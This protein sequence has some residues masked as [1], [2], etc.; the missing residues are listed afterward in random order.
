VLIPTLLSRNQP[1]HPP[2]LKSLARSP[3]NFCEYLTREKLRE[4]I[5]LLARERDHNLPAYIEMTFV[6]LRRVDQRGG[7]EV[8][9][10]MFYEFSDLSFMKFLLANGGIKKEHLIRPDFGVE[11]TL[12]LVCRGSRFYDWR[13]KQPNWRQYENL[14]T[15]PGDRAQLFPPTDRKCRR[16]CIKAR[17]A[18][19]HRH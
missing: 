14:D 5:F 15:D 11:A 8:S 7:V 9:V 2:R 19:F 17:G 16:T 10:M 6:S 4:A 13:E 1:E 3:L 12:G 18:Q